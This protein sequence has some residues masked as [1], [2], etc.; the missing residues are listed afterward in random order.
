MAKS[1]GCDYFKRTSLFWIVF[2]TFGVG[3][4]TC[5]VFAPEKIPFE[6][7]GPFGTFS[8]Y[9]VDNHAEVMYKGWWAALAI[10]VVEALVALKVCSNKG[11]N[12]T[13]TRLMWVFQT[14]L[15]GF[16][17]L[18]PLLKYNPKRPKQH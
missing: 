4:F 2:V 16:A 1:D 6:L 17:S 18:G 5:V 11:I 3:Y 15:F 8:R 13:T 9:L 10:H 14:F 12:S 7:L